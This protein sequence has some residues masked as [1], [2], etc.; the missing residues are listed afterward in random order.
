MENGNKKSLISSIIFCA[1]LFLQSG[2]TSEIEIE[3]IGN[4]KS[5]V[6]DVRPPFT[7]RATVSSFTGLEVTDKSST[8]NPSSRAGEEGYT[9]VFNPGDAIGIF[10]LRNF[11]TPNVAT[12]DGVYNLKLV[13]TK[14]ADGTGSWAPA[15]GDTHALYSYDDNLAYVAYYP[16]RD[17]ITIKQ[18]NK[19]EILKDL[20][21][22]AKLQPAAD[23]STPAAY[24]GS[25]LMAAVARPTLDPANANKKVLT[26]K[27]EH[28]HALLVVKTFTVLNNYTPPSGATFEY[29][30]G[31]PE[32]TAY[33]VIVNGVKALRTDDGI[34][35]AILKANTTGQVVPAGSYRVEGE[36]TVIYTGTTIATGKLTGGKYYTQ[37]VGVSRYPDVSTPRALRVGDYFCSNGKILPGEISFSENLID[38]IGLVFKAGRFAADDSEYVNGNGEVMTTINGYAVA[39][40]D[41]NNGVAIKW[42]N[43]KFA[44]DSN[45]DGSGPYGYFNGFM[46]T[47]LLK[48]DGIGNYPAANTCV[49]YSPA[50]DAI[51]T[52]GWFFP[53]GGQMLELRNTRGELIKKTVFTNYNSGRYWQSVQN[54]S[55]DAW[56]V[57][58]TNGNTTQSFISSAYY[59]RPIVAF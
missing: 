52:S 22:N 3:N 7:I 48:A 9:T 21:N 32:K 39:L 44:L 43:K 49:N 33:D 10:A 51:K 29:L 24:T 54:G 45:R 27:F 59:V 57:G 37:R 53:A 31:V 2:C 58:L 55:G 28:L 16:Y 34:F 18:D 1:V 25:D 41:A 30:P 36:K 40:K 17:G 50:A 47:Q 8:P 26:L 23:Q 4:G 35:R 20:A 46:I 15:I 56:S 19:A 11:E 13:Y 42:G 14:A 12:I 6:H 38:C 5:E